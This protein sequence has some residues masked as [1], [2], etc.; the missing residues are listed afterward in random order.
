MALNSGEESTRTA[1]TLR[2]GDYRPARVCPCFACHDCPDGDTRHPEGCTQCGEALAT[3]CSSLAHFD[4]P[5]FGKPRV[6]VSRPAVV[7]PEFAYRMR[8]ILAQR[9][10]FE[11]FK[12][13]VSALTV[14]MV[15]LATSRR[16]TERVEYKPRCTQHALTGLPSA[17]QCDEAVAVLVETLLQDAATADIVAIDLD[18]KAPMRGDR[19]NATIADHISPFFNHAHVCTTRKNYAL[20][21]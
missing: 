2:G 1:P 4:H 10:P 15:C 19:V 7:S 16:A 13:V 14:F 11:V 6:G 21:L 20:W 18:A 5:R 3:A 8:D 12:A 17:A 9:N